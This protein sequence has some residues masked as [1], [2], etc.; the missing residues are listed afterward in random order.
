LNDLKRV[1]VRLGA[2]AFESDAF[3]V[4]IELGDDLIIHNYIM[5]INIHIDQLTSTFTAHYLAK[6]LSKINPRI[7]TKKPVNTTIKKDFLLQ[8]PL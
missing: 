1:S 6:I 7:I 3:V 8:T 2:F 4:R 5:D